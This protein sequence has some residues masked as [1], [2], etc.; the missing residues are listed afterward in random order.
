MFVQL[1]V[2]WMNH[3]FPVSSFRISSAEQLATLQSLGFAQ[4]RVLPDKSDPLPST[5]APAPSAERAAPEAGQAAPDTAPLLEEQ[6]QELQTCE[7]SFSQATRD[8]QRITDMVLDQ[9]Q[10]A[11]TLGAALVGAC[12]DELLD[13]GDSV[14]RLLSEDV[15]VRS[16]QHP[17]NV[18]VLCLLLG[19]TQQLSGEA[20][21]ALGLAA[22]L[23]DMGKQTL[24]PQVREP[25][26]HLK[27]PDMAR[28]CSHVAASV[29]L[30]QQM[31]LPD[32][33]I[34]AIAEHHERTDG[35][36]FPGGLQ[37]LSLGCYGQMLALVNH[38]DRLCNPSHG[39]TAMTPHEA[40]S[41]LFAQCQSKFDPALLGAF[42]RMMG[43]YPPGSV[44]QLLND[45]Y[46]IVVAVNSARPLR[47]RI[48]LYAPE[49]PKEQAPVLN[50]EDHPDLGIR[51]S[52][53][54]AQLPREVLDYLSPR[55][56]ICY[57]FERAVGAGTAQGWG[58]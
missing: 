55:Q 38:Y 41:I 29:A 14:I 50:L 19:R 25:Y 17:I 27:A 12:V 52:L 21:R 46:A 42:I 3:P 39:A 13:H 18:M 51:R 5:A 34:T 44:V 7:R 23:H 45:R 49:Q 16:A 4:L 36:G 2:G 47:P 9:P 15:G 53:R 54:P 22:L 57:F 33:V 56:R 30:A 48:V 10:Q 31:Q 28:Y 58:A 20:L 6:H 8:Y 32:E 11:C 40:L 24:A 1:D 35:S 37:G 43:V 26:G